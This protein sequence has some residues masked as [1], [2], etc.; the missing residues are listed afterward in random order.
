MKPDNASGKRVLVVE[1]EAVISR[2]CARVLTTEGL[3]VDIANSGLV[4]KDMVKKKEYDLCLIDIRTPGMNGIQLH[5]YLREEHPELADKVI[6]TTGDMLNSD[7]KTFLMDSNRP[8]LPKPFTPDELRAVIREALSK[9]DCL[10][11]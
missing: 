3:E 7:I 1:D 8:H 5:H 4:A 9:L 10:I 11:H 2:V 6:F